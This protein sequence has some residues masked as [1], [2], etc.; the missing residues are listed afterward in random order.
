MKN[1]IK[2][3]ERL[4]KSVKDEGFDIINEGAST[5]GDGFSRRHSHTAD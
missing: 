5:T 2:Q 1:T 3:E 4:N